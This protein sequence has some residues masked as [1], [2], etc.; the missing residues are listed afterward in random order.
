MKHTIYE[1]PDDIFKE[2]VTASVTILVSQTVFDY[3]HPSALLLP[4]LLEAFQRLIKNKSPCHGAMFPSSY[5]H[6]IFSE[7]TIHLS[8][9]QLCDSKGNSLLL[10]LLQQIIPL[11]CHYVHNPKDTITI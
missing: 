11:T 2:N 1:K 8:E 6:I 9:T 7:V 5:H 3:S 4:K 10:P